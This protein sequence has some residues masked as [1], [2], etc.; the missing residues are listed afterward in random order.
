MSYEL[1]GHLFEVPTSDGLPLFVSGNQMALEISS[2]QYFEIENGQ[3]KNRYYGKQPTA[4]SYINRF[5]RDKSPLRHFIQ[6]IIL[7][8]CSER[9][10]ELPYD[11]R[12]SILFGLSTLLHSFG[13]KADELP[14]VV[15]KGDEI[16]KALLEAALETDKRDS[17]LLHALA[18]LENSSG[19]AFSKDTFV[20]LL[21]DAA[22]AERSEIVT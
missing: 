20:S 8:V 9:T 11:E 18:S 7:G 21:H 22:T 13:T 12:C 5:L 2:Y 6:S 19:F 14:A 1:R 17:E 10:R 16:P 3:L 15:R 4:V